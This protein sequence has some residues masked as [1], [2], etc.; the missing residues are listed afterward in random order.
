MPL[1]RY[2]PPGFVFVP[3]GVKLGE[4]LKQLGQ[5]LVGATLWRYWPEHGGWF[6]ADVTGFNE[7]TAEHCLT[8][9]KGRSNETFE[10]CDL[11]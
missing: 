10:W 2:L 9:D 11:R 4:Q 5:V 8:Y 1:A 7:E 6:V 3:P